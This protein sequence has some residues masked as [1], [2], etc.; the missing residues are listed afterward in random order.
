MKSIVNRSAYFADAK[1]SNECDQSSATPPKKSEQNETVACNSAAYPSRSKKRILSTNFRHRSLV[2][3]LY[4]YQEDHRV[5]LLHICL[6]IS[7]LLQAH[8]H[9]LKVP[10]IN[11]KIFR[12]TKDPLLE[13]F[14]ERVEYLEPS[15]LTRFTVTIYDQLTRL[16][17]IL[18]K[19]F[20][21][22]QRMVDL[23]VIGRTRIVGIRA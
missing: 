19:G 15:C 23:Q 16:C 4:R 18:Q 20:G 17:L 6:L 13:C 14:V 10:L 1:T 8:N 9:M 11:A 5:L 22:M 12:S 7:Q 21:R 2:N 3:H